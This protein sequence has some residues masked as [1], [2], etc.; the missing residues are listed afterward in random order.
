MVMKMR[1]KLRSMAFIMAAFFTVSQ[2]LF[3]SAANI[4]EYP[5]IKVPT[6]MSDGEFF[7]VWDGAQNSWEHT[8]ET[9]V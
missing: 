1:R 5:E 4:S 9:A 6:H 8:A 2:L 7:G 3:V